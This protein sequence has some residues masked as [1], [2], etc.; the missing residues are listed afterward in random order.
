MA[1]V[2]G[3][4]MAFK[5]SMASYTAAGPS[6]VI[7]LIL[8]P[9]IQRFGVAGSVLNLALIASSFGTNDAGFILISFVTVSMSLS[10]YEVK[11]PATF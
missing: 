1:S 5:K 11:Y 7:R 9:V 8:V 2:I 3:A 4:E 10:N 6:L